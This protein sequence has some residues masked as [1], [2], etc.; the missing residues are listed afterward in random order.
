MTRRSY[1]ASYGSGRVSPTTPR[2]S[3]LTSGLHLHLGMRAGD[4]SEMP[5]VFVDISGEYVAA[6]ADGKV[7]PV[8]AEA[9]KRADH[10]PIVVNGRM[11]I[12]IGALGQFTRPGP[13]LA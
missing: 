8:I 7:D 13:C 1:Y 10:V 11:Q 9:L 3:R 6:L 4:D 12:P 2:T 5:I